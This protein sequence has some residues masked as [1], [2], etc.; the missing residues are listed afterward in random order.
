MGSDKNIVV[1]KCI[2]FLCLMTTSAYLVG[3]LKEQRF[4]S[5]SVL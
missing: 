2:S 5:I 1:G 3:G 4:I